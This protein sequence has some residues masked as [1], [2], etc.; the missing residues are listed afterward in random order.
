MQHK[1]VQINEL[2]DA[3]FSL[4]LN[5]SLGYEEISFNVVKKCFN[6]FCEPYKHVFNLYIETGVFLYKLKIALV[7][8]VYK[9]GGSSDLTNCRPISVPPCFSKILER[10]IYNYLFSCV[11]RKKFYIQNNLIFNLAI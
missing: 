5:K 7:S 11:P 9:T 2:R 4:K 10:T 6:E 1:L 3:F 8:P